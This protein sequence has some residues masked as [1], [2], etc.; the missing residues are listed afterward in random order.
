MPRLADVTDW[1]NE[2]QRSAYPDA[3]LLGETFPLLLLEIAQ[4][5]PDQPVFTVADNILAGTPFD[6]EACCLRSCR[7]I[8]GGSTDYADAQWQGYV[9]ALALYVSAS[10]AAAMDIPV[11]G[12]EL[13]AVL[14]ASPPFKL[15][16]PLVREKAASF[17]IQHE[18]WGAQ[19]LV[20]DDLFD[21]RRFMNKIVDLCEAAS[22]NPDYHRGV[23]TAR[24]T[25]MLYVDLLTDSPV[26][27]SEP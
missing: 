8:E 10:G 16:S 15:L 3:L 7:Q 26:A 17:V 20:P 9:D 13:L 2:R 25:M 19:N 4:R 27:S 23:R 18:Q 22:S 5:Q 1:L 21:G 12:G 11:L 14:N 24:D 6:A